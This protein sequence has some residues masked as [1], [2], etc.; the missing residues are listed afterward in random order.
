MAAGMKTPLEIT[1][2]GH[3]AVR[4]AGSRLVFLDPFLTGN[5]SA[6]LKAEAIREADIIAVTHDHGDHLG[7]AFA[8][9]KR[10]GAEIV[11][12]N[13]LANDATAQGL[14]GV[15]FNIGGTVE[16]RGVRFHMVAAV[17]SAG[18]GAPA[19]LV[20]EMDGKRIYHAGD[21]GLTYDMKLVGEFFAPDLAFLPIGDWFTMGPASA[22]MAV[23]F[24]RAKRVVPIHYGTFPVLTGDPEEFKARVGGAAE[25][26]ILKPGEK[27]LL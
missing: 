1:F 6:S 13:E 17:H 3:S 18:K 20:L 10:T 5:P 15:G 24:I 25:V 9:A 14:K 7:D 12:I 2:L 23:E 22:A 26:I 27:T 19:G 16:V 4:I 21:T 11:A 8:I